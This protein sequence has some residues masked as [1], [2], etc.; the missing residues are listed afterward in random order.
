MTRLLVSICCLI[1]AVPAA[2]SDDRVLY[3]NI[4]ERMHEGESYY[5]VAADELRSGGYPLKPVPA[6]RPPTLA[7][8]LAH[9]P[10]RLSRF[11]VLIA[12]CLAAA[13]AW[14]RALSDLPT[15]QRVST[16]TLLM[17]GLA[18]VGAPN[19][20]YLHETWAICF[21]ALSLAFY[22][23]LG[24]CI[25]FA[26]IA[27][28]IR[29]TSIL[30][31]I[32]MGLVAL[33][34]RDWKRALWLIAVG[35]LS[36]GMWFAHSVAVSTVVTS[37]DPVS[38][39]WVVSGGLPMVLAAAKWNILTSQLSGFPLVAVVMTFLLSLIAVRRVELKVAA[40]YVALFCIALLFLGRPDNDYWGI[41]FAPFLA[42]GLPS[43]V[44]FLGE[45]WNR[46]SAKPG[47]SIPG[48]TQ[49]RTASDAEELN[50]APR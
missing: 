31:A 12:L 37:A 29:E 44:K 23:N 43:V 34:T 20:I 22:R 46:R 27:V 21:I 36:A 25:A 40:V 5:D 14:M 10:T 39:G 8:A 13:L 18:N 1:L 48:I 17:S 4:V 38:P 24:L 7:F 26:F 9:L 16:I 49:A 50:R 45:I 33:T 15:W 42:L 3:Q 6:F 30:F 28:L 47:P 41:M 2:A 35:L 19:S 32:A 11:F